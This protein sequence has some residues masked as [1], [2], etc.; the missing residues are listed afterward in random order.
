MV[1]E[2]L[3]T[4]GLFLITLGVNVGKY[5]STMDPLGLVV[6]QRKALVTCHAT[7]HILNQEKTPIFM[8]IKTCSF[9][10]ETTSN[11]SVFTIFAV[12]VSDVCSSQATDC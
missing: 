5:S 6:L 4:L 3:P 9:F 1:L 2:Y 8:Q 12:L 11:R 7:D 10:C